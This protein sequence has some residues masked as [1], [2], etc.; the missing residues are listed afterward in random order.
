MNFITI[1][2]NSRK[3]ILWEKTEELEI[4]VDNLEI[5]E[6]FLHKC[7][8]RMNNILNVFFKNENM[9]EISFEHYDLNKLLNDFKTYFKYIE[10]AGG[11]VKNDKNELLVIHRFGIPDLPK[12]KIEK[13]E[14]PEIAAIREVE[15]ECGISNL[16]IEKELKPS[17]HIYDYNNKKVLKK[18]F[19]FKM[20]YS[21]NEPLIPQIEEDITKV[22]WCNAEKIKSY[23]KQTYKNLKIYFTN[24]FS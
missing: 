13:E 7:T 21:G 17:Y 15:E 16:K 11:V 5:D 24:N 9:Q 3:I 19:W 8:D 2:Y 14:T 20:Q 12:G 22:E 23:S 6:P 18:T 1:Y 4:K 10:A